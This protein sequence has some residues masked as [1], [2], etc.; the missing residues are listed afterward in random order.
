MI[1]E[2]I[3]HYRIIEKLGEGGM[4]VVY[5]AED[6]RLERTVAL[7]FLPPNALGSPE[8]RKR[9]LQEAQAIAKLHHPNIC[10]IYEIDKVDDKAFIAMA[11][12]EGREL[13]DV[14][15]EGPMD[16]GFAMDVAIQVAEGLQDAHEN[17]IV[18]RDVKA[19]NIMITDKGRALVMDFGLARRTD[20]T[21]VTEAGMAMG[22]VDYMSPEQAR[23]DDVDYRTDVWSFGVTLFEMIAGRRPFRGDRGEAVVFSIMNGEHEPLTALRTGV[24][25]ELERIVNKC[26]AKRPEERYQHMSDLIVDLKALRQELLGSAGITTSRAVPARRIPFAV[27]LRQRRVPQILIAYALA[28]LGIVLLTSWLVNRYPISPHAPEF[29]LALLLSL[30]PTVFLYSFFHGSGGGRWSKAERIG[31]PANLVLAALVLFVVFQNKDLGAATTTISV[32]DEAGNRVERVIPKAEFRKRVALFYFN[33]ES[34]DP[35]W[36]WLQYGLIHLLR[37]DLYQDIYVS[38]SYGF[39]REQKRRG[40]DDPTSSPLTLKRTIANDFHYQYFTAGSFRI[41]DDTFSIRVTLHEASNGRVVSAR[42]YRGDNVH[43]LVDSISLLLRRDVDIPAYHIAE[44]PDLPIAEILTRSL[45]ALKFY[46]LAVES[47]NRDNDYVTAARHIEQAVELDP[48]YVSALWRQF[49]IYMNTNR[50]EEAQRAIDAAMKYRYKLPEPTQFA[51]RHDYYDFANR[52]DEAFENARRWMKLYPQDADAHQTLASLYEQTQQWDLAILERQKVFELDPEGYNQLRGIATI[53]AKK[54]E[55]EQALAYLER[56]AELFPD[57]HESWTELGDL[58]RTVGRFEEAKTYYKKALVT[59]PDRMS[60]RTSIA[61]VERNLGNF[62]AALRQCNEA[63]ASAK[64]PQDS[65]EVLGALHEYYYFRGETR[66]ALDYHE[67]NFEVASRYVSPVGLLFWRMFTISIYADA[68]QEQV[69]F[70]LI[71]AMEQQDVPAGLRPLLNVGRLILMATIADPKQADVYEHRLEEFTG[72]ID[73]ARIEQARW[74]VH[75]LTAILDEWRGDLR[76]ALDNAQ[77]ALE[78]IDQD[79]R[80]SI[81]QINVYAGYVS[82]ELGRYEMAEGYLKQALA[83]EPFQPWAHFELAR[84]Y[85]SLGRHQEAQ[86]HL[87]KTLFVWENADPVYKLAQEAY[88]TREEWERSEDTNRP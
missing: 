5:K 64:T 41:N 82:R 12:V 14:I 26:L 42:T 19:A 78:I 27:R 71:D 31:I 61:G 11:F 56:Y 6:T 8:S 2:T 22:T 36:D 49:G 33:N 38:V 30:V 75:F 67:R 65:S 87:D 13:R 66:R 62:D 21:A 63:L 53:Y 7:K 73:A 45:D 84:V 28:G 58:Y 44:S 25:M 48:T 35:S 57:K 46:V 88:A 60:I 18:H 51:L 9:F 32:T 77:K 83:I 81:T 17:G 76:A 79:E 54:G 43:S 37:Y 39:S 55:P 34:G 68:A 29:A 59:D 15:A 16:L 24:P 70:D 74:A 23:G 85:R 47:I 72:F 52:T 20:Q 80:E 69:A 40:V 86:S 10:T 50:G 1:D 3:S 4:G